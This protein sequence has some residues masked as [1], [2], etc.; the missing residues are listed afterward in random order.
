MRAYLATVEAT[1]T[2]GKHSLPTEWMSLCG[3][4]NVAVDQPLSI[5]QGEEH[6]S[7][8][9]ILRWNP[10]VIFTNEPDVAEA[11]ARDSKWSSIRAVQKKKIYHMPIGISRWG[12]PGSLETPLAML[13]TAKTVYP[14]L[15]TGMDIKIEVEKYYRKFFRLKLT[16]ALYEQMLS[17]KGMRKPKRK[18]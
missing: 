2:Y 7:L 12:H 5:H 14:N 4:V 13:W 6:A 3:I 11:I 17:G 15:F 8:E 1:R 9:Q 18:K 10:D 16:D